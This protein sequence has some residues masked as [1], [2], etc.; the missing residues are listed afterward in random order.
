MPFHLVLILKP[1][2]IEYKT[3]PKEKNENGN[4]TPNVH[5]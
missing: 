1:L 4:Q 2:V 3:I 5:H